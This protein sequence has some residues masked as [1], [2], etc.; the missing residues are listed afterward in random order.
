MESYCATGP[1]ARKKTTL[2][3]ARIAVGFL[4]D[5]DLAAS[6]L[7]RLAILAPNR[8][9]TFAASPSQNPRRLT[10]ALDRRNAHAAFLVVPCRCTQGQ[11]ADLRV[12]T[13]S[14][15]MEA[16]VEIAAHDID[17]KEIAADTMPLTCKSAYAC[18]GSRLL[19]RV[20]KQIPSE[21]P[22]AMILAT[23]HSASPT[24]REPLRKA[25]RLVARCIDT[26]LT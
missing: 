9:W 23:P 6:F 13:R 22:T 5:L 25:A 17:A 16:L 12:I 24:S 15:I 10:R 1:C 2:D 14:P 7:D 26:L 8:R 3:D 19:Y 4:G 21:L 20:M 11:T 18:A